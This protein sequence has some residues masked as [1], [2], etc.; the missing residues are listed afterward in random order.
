MSVIYVVEEL[1]FV[2]V[3]IKVHDNLLSKEHI[4]VRTSLNLLLSQCRMELPV[5]FHTSVK[6]EPMR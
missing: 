2:V 1:F 5:N 3:I 6:E 4:L